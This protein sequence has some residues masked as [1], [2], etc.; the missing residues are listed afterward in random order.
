MRQDIC[1]CLTACFPWGF[2]VDSAVVVQVD[3]DFGNIERLAGSACCFGVF[4]GVHRGHRCLI[5]ATIADAHERGT[6]AVVVT[7]DIDPDELFDPDGLRKLMSNGARIDALAQTGVDCVL[8]LP[9]TKEFAALEP[10]DFLTTCFGVALPLSL[11][12][13]S[14]FRFGRKA[15]G[16]VYELSLWGAKHG[17]AVFAHDL[18]ELS[19][20]PVSATR[21]R[22]L[23]FDGRNIKQANKLLGRPY[24]MGGRVER[25]RQEGR[26]M[27]FRTANVFVA[28]QL[29]ALGEGV[30]AAYATVDGN[31]YKAAVSVGVSPTFAD[32][33]HAFCEAHLLDFDADIYGDII[34]LDFIEWLRP[35]MKF[36]DVDELISTVMGNI[37]WVRANL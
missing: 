1:G 21:I 32:E 24:R 20:E 11:N 25:G 7:F 13:G 23:L 31:R 14:N 2:L 10:E 35:M 3:S 34:E 15:K 27:G 16:D 8:V 29:R 17:M 33:T 19:G 9:F 4:D 6:N 22:K 26:D 36:D 18:E 12:V 37:N 30:Y 5:D 28:K